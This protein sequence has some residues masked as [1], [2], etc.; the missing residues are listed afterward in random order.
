M[1]GCASST[2]VLNAATECPRSARR[3][4]A[5]D[6]SS[7]LPPPRFGTRRL[8]V[9][10]RRRSPRL[11]GAF[12][13]NR[14]ADM[15]EKAGVR[16]TIR[17][18]EWWERKLSP[19]FATIYATAYLLQ[20]PILPLWPLLLVALVALIPGAAYVS[21]VNDL[22]DRADDAASGKA[23][24]LAGRSFGFAVLML[25]CCIVPGIVV[26]IQW[27][28]DR[29]PLS[30]Y[31]AAWT[32]FSLYSIP[33]V[34]PEESR[35]PRH[36]RRRL[37]RASVSDAARRHPRLP[38]EWPAGGDDVVRRGRAVVAVQRAARHHVASA[39]RSVAPTSR[40]ALR[41]SPRVT[42]RRRWNG[43]EPS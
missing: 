12:T 24:R 33:P 23:N 8:M 18:G 41:P 39:R 19:M 38:L 28:G 17:A 2:T 4:A 32:A 16:E 35:R 30:L 40:S 1:A 15:Q 22:T 21:A 25:A 36:H 14:S 5:P 13:T 20:I 31:L 26:A 9:T 42:S 27:R 10:K 11:K 6:H 7:S 37:W 3:V 29:L 34:P 43:W